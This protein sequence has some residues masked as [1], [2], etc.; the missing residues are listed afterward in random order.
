MFN[1]YRFVYFETVIFFH[2]NSLLLINFLYSYT[3]KNQVKKSYEKKSAPQKY[4]FLVYLFP[5]IDYVL[6]V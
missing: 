1:L 4:K 3:P 6:H 5:L 2:D